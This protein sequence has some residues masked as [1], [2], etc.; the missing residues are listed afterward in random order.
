MERDQELVTALEELNRLKE[1]AERDAQLQKA[2]KA[3]QKQL[4]VRTPR[5]LGCLVSSTEDVYVWF[6]A[7]LRPTTPH[8]VCGVHRTIGGGCRSVSSLH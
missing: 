2:L 8:G 4:Q 1:D 5:P 7:A 3:I 6:S